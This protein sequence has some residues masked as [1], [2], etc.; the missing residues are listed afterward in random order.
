M[1]ETDGTLFA[2]CPECRVL[3][4]DVQGRRL[5]HPCGPKVG[6]SVFKDGVSSLQTSQRLRSVETQLAR[7][8]VG[9]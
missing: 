9:R 1:S 8:V 3:F 7:K 6:R 4:L 5:I 2:Y